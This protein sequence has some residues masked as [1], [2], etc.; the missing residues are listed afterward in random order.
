MLF[1][2]CYHRFRN[3]IS[4]RINFYILNISI[5]SL[6]VLLYLINI[7]VI[8][9]TYA[10]T[11]FFKNYF[12]DVLAGIVLLSYTKILLS[13]YSGKYYLKEKLHWYLLFILPAGLFWEFV[14]PLYKKSSVAD[15]T[16][17]LFYLVGGV[18]Y[19]YLERIFKAGA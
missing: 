5:L 19:F 17:I 6:S 11:L 13:F 14:T 7:Y 3:N 1:I 15:I 12:N 10:S 9:G 16:D 2:N 8:K 4:N 18:I